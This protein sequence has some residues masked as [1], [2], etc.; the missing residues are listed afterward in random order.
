MPIQRTLRIV[1]AALALGFVVLA[2]LVGQ[3]RQ[4]QIETRKLVLHTEEVLVE[5]GVLRGSAL[6]GDM[7]C[8]GF[9]LSGEPRY[10]DFQASEF[11]Q[12]DRHLDKLAELVADNPR[13]SPRVT[14]IREVI[15]ERKDA[16]VSLMALRQTGGLATA[17][18]AF[19]EGDA[20]RRMDVLRR[21][22]TEMEQ[23]EQGLLVV[24]DARLQASDRVLTASSAAA[25]V[26]VLGLVIA[27]YFLFRRDAKQREALEGD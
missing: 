17:A 8:R 4:R 1:F 13:Q 14:R 26:M 9:V 6:D 7:A 27:A 22:L 5:I 2:V 25:G 15:Q 11:A 24:R 3:S 20:K 23:E 10:R 16:C 18:R 12:A 21:L 19:T